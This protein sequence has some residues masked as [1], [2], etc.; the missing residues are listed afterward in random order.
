[1]QIRDLDPPCSQAHTRDESIECFRWR[2]CYLLCLVCLSSL[3]SS[4]ILGCD[5]L[6]CGHESDDADPQCPLPGDGVGTT[7][8][9][10]N[11]TAYGPLSWTVVGNT[12]DLINPGAPKGAERLTKSFYLGTP[13]SILLQNAD[14]HGC[15]LLY[16]NITAALQTVPGFDDFANFGCDTVLGRQ[17]A[18]DL[19][20]Q[21]RQALT[22][23]LSADP[24]PEDG[25]CT[26]VQLA[27]QNRRMPDSCNLP[28]GRTSW[29]SIDVSGKLPR[30][31][32]NL[33]VT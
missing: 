2:Y 29:G 23:R 7:T 10:S 18:Q 15:S 21:A 5:T 8:F 20:E 16:Y 6:D 1:M 22:D 17:C 30:V 31:P 32:A 12:D 14:F 24:S 19:L 27:L 25:V 26:P 13:S 11:L 33:A 3:A 9:Q 28:F 4:Q